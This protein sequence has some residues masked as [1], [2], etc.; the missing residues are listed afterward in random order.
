MV[1][2]RVDDEL[3]MGTSFAVTHVVFLFTAA[4]LL[5]RIHWQ[6][7]GNATVGQSEQRIEMTTTRR[8]R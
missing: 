7:T 3:I 5:L 4:Y 2:E 8:K 6:F 1:T